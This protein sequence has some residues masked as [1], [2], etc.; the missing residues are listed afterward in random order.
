MKTTVKVYL[1]NGNSW[2]TT[3]NLNA[4][5]AVDY[6]LG[7]YWNISMRDDLMSKC[8]KVDVL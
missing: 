2:V 3:I 7:Q 8:I 6:Y 5:D 4:A 1:E